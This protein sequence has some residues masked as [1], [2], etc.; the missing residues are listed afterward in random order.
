MKKVCS[1]DAFR[2]RETLNQSLPLQNQ[3]ANFKPNID[4]ANVFN[5]ILC[6]STIGDFGKMEKIHRWHSGFFFSETLVVF[7]YQTWH[8]A[9]S[10]GMGMHVRLHERRHPFLG[11]IIWIQISSFPELEGLYWLNS[12]QSDLKKGILICWNKTPC[13]VLR[14]YSVM[15]KYR[16]YIENILKSSTE[17]LD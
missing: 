11:G 5:E 8:R 12:D 3:W 10:L 9:S 7:F 1:N 16:K 6:S 15:V 14:G 2:L 17:P 4:V 13:P